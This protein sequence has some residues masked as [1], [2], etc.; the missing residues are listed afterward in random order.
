[1]T[2]GAFRPAREVR[3]VREGDAPGRVRRRGEDD[4]GRARGGLA[5]KIVALRAGL[6]RIVVLLVGM[7][8]ETGVPRGRRP[9]M[10]DVTGGA[11]RRPVGRGL[12][13]TRAIRM[14]PDAVRE[15]LDLLF[16]QVALVAR[17]TGHRRPGRADLMT[18]A[19]GGGLGGAARVTHAAREL[20]MPPSQLPGMGKGRSGL[21]ALEPGWRGL[22][23]IVTHPA[24][25]VDDLAFLADVPAVVTPRA[26]RKLLVADVVGIGLPAHAH[27]GEEVLSVDA[28]D[29]LR[30]G[31][32]LR[33]AAARDRRVF[34]RVELPNG[35]LDARVR[36]GRRGVGANQGLDGDLL[37]ERQ[38]GRE[39]AGAEALVD[40]ARRRQ[41]PMARAI[42]AIHAVHAPEGARLE[43]RVRE[44]MVLRDVLR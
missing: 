39:P 25:R 35:S 18:P 34:A 11:R 15:R 17:E 19:T 16:L 24:I 21:H 13:Q 27:L 7:A 40:G 28:L 38:V 36:L 32:H 37:D 3:S 5:A 20:R 4:R 31:A 9:R 6:P 2:I 44:R 43:L 23:E 41:E 29:L 26:P 22:E 10:R 30:G 1:M 8:R 33:L 14:A 42:V 12:V